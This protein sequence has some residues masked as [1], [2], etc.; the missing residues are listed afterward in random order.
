[1]ARCICRTRE[2]A[3]T[4]ARYDG[5]IIKDDL[6]THMS[7]DMDSAV[8]QTKDSITDTGIFEYTR[9]VE[10]NGNSS[11]SGF[12]KAKKAQAWKR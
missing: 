3:R 8:I 10:Q 6:D 7:R 9:D 11:M 1:M 2:A 4:S 12:P 5:L